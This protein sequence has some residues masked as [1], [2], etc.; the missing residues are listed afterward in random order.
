[1][2]HYESILWVNALANLVAALAAL[3]GVV[4]RR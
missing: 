1:M 2:T 4:R 3:I